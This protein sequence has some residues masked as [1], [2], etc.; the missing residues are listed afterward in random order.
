[1]TASRHPGVRQ[2]PFSNYQPWGSDCSIPSSSSC[3]LRKSMRSFVA[4]GSGERVGPTGRPIMIIAPLSDEGYCSLKSFHSPE[5]LNWQSRA[6]SQSRST[7]DWKNLLQRFGA[8][9]PDEE[10]EPH[11]PSGYAESRCSTPW[12]IENP[13][14]IVSATREISRN[15]SEWKLA[16]FM[17]T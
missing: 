17:P 9:A 7:I 10:N 5:I 16:S 6:V 3:D 13:G 2:D 1:M 15:F 4:V 14:R 11:A 8:I 12:M